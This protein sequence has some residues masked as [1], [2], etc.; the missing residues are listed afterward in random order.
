M[1]DIIFGSNKSGS[2]L[3]NTL[4]HNLYTAVNQFKVS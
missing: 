1:Y 2:S 4:G 3:Q